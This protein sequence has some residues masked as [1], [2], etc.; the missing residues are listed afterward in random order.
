MSA[1]ARFRLPRRRAMHPGD[2][3]GAAGA[4]GP[5]RL[6]VVVRG[7][8]QGVGFRPFVH[9]LAHELGLAGWVRNSPQGVFLEAEGAA[10]QLESFLVRLQSEKPPPASIQSLEASWL[11][12]A[13]HLGFVI[14]PSETAGDPTTL[15][16]PDIVTCE[17]CRREIFDPG[18]RR[19]LYPFTN[20]THC[21]PRYSI[22]EGL[23]Y[24]RARTSMRKFGLC[25]QCQAEYEN[26]ADRRFHAQ[27]NACPRCGPHL[28][29][30]DRNGRVLASHRQALHAAVGALRHG[31][32]VA[33]K[34]LGG[35]QLLATA[36]CEATVRGL[37]VLKQREEKPFAVMFASV[38]AVRAH[39]EVS[40]LEERLLRSPEGPIVLVRRKREDPALAVLHAAIVPAVAPG[41]P[42]LG[43]LLPTTPLH[44]LLLMA[45]AIPVVATSGNVADEPI[46]VEEREALT[47]L[48]GVAEFFLVHNR[49][50][51]RHVDDSVARVVLGREMLLRRARGY[52]PLPLPLPPAG[53]GGAG[54]GGARDSGPVVLAVGAHLKSAVA[55]AVGGQV[56]GGQHVGDLETEAAF[57]ALRRTAHDLEQLYAARPGVVAADWHPDYLSG[58]W[59]EGLAGAG[60]GAPVLVRVQH[61]HAHVLACLAD[62]GLEDPVLGVA[63]DGT[64][65]GPDGTVWGGEFLAVEGAG[66]RRVA[67][68]RPFRLAGGEQAVRE[69]R[70]SAVGLLHEVEGPGWTELEEVASVRALR[71][72]E[73]QVLRRMLERGV[74]SPATTSAGRFF[75]ALA[76]VLGLRHVCRHEGQAAMALE[77]ACDEAGEAEAYPLPLVEAAA[78]RLRGCGEESA[79]GAG[80][81]GAGVAPLGGGP[82]WVLDWAPLLAGV[83]ADLARGV[84]VGRVAWRIHLAL[85]EGVVAVARRVG[86]P[87]VVLTGG[88]FQNRILLEQAVGRLQAAGFRP[89]WHQRIPPNDGGIAAGQAV[90]ARRQVAA[91]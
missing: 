45:L 15:V 65:W 12:P 14:Q 49:P 81:G 28:E 20:C 40:G 13:G 56:F 27:P 83:R 1:A 26:P 51:V 63:W 2:E 76:S 19:Y 90:A 78:V 74:N 24:D 34:G 18:N 59:A 11:D 30:W 22:I 53:A 44:H 60:A 80:G 17:A 29:F 71:P 67:C 16:L 69:P 89:Y 55:L 86:W 31:S 39:G 64:G 21:G 62:N 23:P 32:I 61:H 82:A 46:C 75:D 88:C 7:A 37:R 6:R 5:R 42:Y 58:R 70:R 43:V 57:D 91:S 77:F 25:E 50:I 33:V 54:S 47:R 66:Y 35:F 8:V 3:I 72:V 87:R 52:A 84:G 4:S 79:G 36:L 85:A 73:R 9:R 68:L 48:R 10:G 41:N 38:E